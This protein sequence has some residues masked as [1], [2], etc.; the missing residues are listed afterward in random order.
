[1]YFGEL[2]EQPF[3]T[4]SL[5]SVTTAK[6]GH[7]DSAHIDGQTYVL[8]Q[9]ADVSLAHLMSV[10]SRYSM[11]LATHGSR[12]GFLAAIIAREI[13]QSAEEIDLVRR[14][15]LLHDIGKVLVPWQIYA[16]PG[17]LSASETEQMKQHPTDGERLCASFSAL[18]PLLPIIRHHHERLDG[19]GYP[20]RLKGDQIPLGAQI[21]AVAD[22]YDA[23]TSDRFYR[24]AQSPRQASIVLS[25]ACYGHLNSQL[26]EALLWGLESDKT[27]TESI[28]FNPMVFENEHIA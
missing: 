13:G 23:L 10:M 20:D 14:A 25:Q 22:Y 7:H 4:N 3:F 28:C 5:P 18:S 17:E 1:M 8:H 26:V 27:E 19:T 2:S 6:F 21:V 16:K 12:V 24:R 9:G 11:E 15:G